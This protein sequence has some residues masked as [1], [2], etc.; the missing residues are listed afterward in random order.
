MFS[1]NFVSLG[2]SSFGLKY[3]KP[4][5]IVSVTHVMLLKSS[6]IVCILL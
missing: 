6:S 4:S 3:I 1:L 5:S 2:V